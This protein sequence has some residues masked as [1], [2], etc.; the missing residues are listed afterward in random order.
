[1]SI[2]YLKFIRCETNSYWDEYYN[3]TDN[4]LYDEEWRKYICFNIP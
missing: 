4:Y 3:N 2:K 1:M